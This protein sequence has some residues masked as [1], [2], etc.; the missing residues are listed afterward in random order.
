MKIK[1]IIAAILAFIL[2]AVVLFIANGMVGNPIS[3]M[4]QIEQLQNI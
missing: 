3:Q 1:K 2:I 4:L